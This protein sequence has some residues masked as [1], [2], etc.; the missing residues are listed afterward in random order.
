MIKC[1]NKAEERYRHLTA[2]FVPARV[3]ADSCCARLHIPYD[4][5]TTGFSLHNLRHHW[6][7][8]CSR[9]TMTLIFIFFLVPSFLCLCS[10]IFSPSIPDSRIC[11]WG[12]IPIP[13]F[14]TFVHSLSYLYSIRFLLVFVFHSFISFVLSYFLFTALALSL[15]IFIRPSSPLLSFSLPSLPS[16]YSSSSFSLSYLHSIRFLLFFIFLSS[17]FHNL[18]L[19]FFTSC[20]LFVA[21]K[22]ILR[23]PHRWQ[24]VVNNAGDYTEGQ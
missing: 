20:F 1:P 17:F 21:A 16:L 13:Y 7:Q 10:V 4:S 5:W 22:V 12:V 6:C 9:F 3:A 19:P 8:R 23:L 15:I 18:H 11:S 14:S 24:R 2:S